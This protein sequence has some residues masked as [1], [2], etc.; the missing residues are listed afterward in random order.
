MFSGRN[1]VNKCWLL[2]D[3]AFEENYENKRKKLKAGRR[4][5]TMAL[6]MRMVEV[7]GL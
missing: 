4:N 6:S 2:L 3:W 1:L 7:Q 5:E